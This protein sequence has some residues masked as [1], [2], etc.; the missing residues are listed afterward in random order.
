MSE[1]VSLE[2]LLP[3]AKD[4]YL[5]A[6]RAKVPMETATQAVPIEK[7]LPQVADE[8]SD[9]ILRIHKRLSEQE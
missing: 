6:V 3:V 7:R 9:F 4:I 2:A 8:F 1:K 5:Q